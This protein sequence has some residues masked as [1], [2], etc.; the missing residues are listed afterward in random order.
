MTRDEER[1]Y[2]LGKTMVY[3]E[4][5]D[6]GMRGLGG[7]ISALDVEADANKDVALARLVKERIDLIHTISR[8][9]RAHGDTAW[10]IHS[11][12]CD[13][14]ERHLVRHL[15]GRIEELESREPESER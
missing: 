4:M 5:L 9:C 7:I 6:A 2:D 10:S 14:V 15:V 12:L 3:R 1:A 11:N 8:L 13:V